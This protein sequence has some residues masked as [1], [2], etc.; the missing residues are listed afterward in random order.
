MS[1][2]VVQCVCVRVCMVFNMAQSNGSIMSHVVVFTHDRL[3]S[4]KVW[5]NAVSTTVRLRT[6]PST[7]SI[8]DSMKLSAP[9]RRTASSSSK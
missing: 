8:R 5:L 2:K 7:G 9:R 1:P 4:Q 6:F 3:E